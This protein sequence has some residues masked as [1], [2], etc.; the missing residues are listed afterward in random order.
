M[1]IKC[2]LSV[3]KRKGGERLSGWFDPVHIKMSQGGFI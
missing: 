3:W 2:I 1:T